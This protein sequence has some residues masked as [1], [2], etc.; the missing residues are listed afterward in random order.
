MK[1]KTK[2]V[3]VVV[4]PALTATAVV[5]A[6]G[7]GGQGGDVSSGAEE[8][9]GD[10]A[11]GAGEVSTPEGGSPETAISRAAQ[12]CE[13]LTTLTCRMRMTCCGEEAM[14]DTILE[15]RRLHDGRV[16]VTDSPESESAWAVRVEVS[17]DGALETEAGVP[18][19]S[20]ERL[21]DEYAE[22]GEWE[23]YQAVEGYPCSKVDAALIRFFVMEWFYFG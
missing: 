14:I 11:I 6:L 20:C 19:M 10:A 16:A 22:T 21:M 3:A 13:D 4:R 12:F 9:R 2:S 5:V 15:V 23:T 17:S 8:D 18:D 7:C 1:G